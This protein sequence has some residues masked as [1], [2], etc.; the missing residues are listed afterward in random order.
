MEIL[1]LTI[2][3]YHRAL[4]RGELTTRQLVRAYLDRIEAYDQ[5]G[6]RI[7]A[8]ISTN[9]QAME[10]AEELDRRFA[11]SGLT[12]PLHGV[13]VLLKDN[14]HTA[15]M[16]TTAGSESLRGFMAGSDAPLVGR[17]K[18]AGAI[19]LAKT[20]LHEFAIWGE[21]ISSIA[22]QTLNPYDLTRTPGGS[23]G[24]T[25][26]AVAANLGLVGIGTDTINSIRSPSSANA[27]VGIRPTLGRVSREGIVPYSYT[28]DTAGPMTRCVADAAR[29]L[30]VIQGF[31][32]ADEATASCQDRDLHLTDI[33]EEEDGLR[34]ARIGVLE[35]FFGHGPH[36]GAVNAAVRGALAAMERMGAVLVPIRTPLDA[37]ELTKNVSVHLYDLKDH[38]NLYLSKLPEN[39]PVHSMEEVLASGKF[40]PG[41]RE[42]LEQ[43]A[44][45]STGTEE[46]ARRLARG[47]ETRELI[48]QWMDKNNLDALA[49]PHQQQLVCKVG[50]AQQER[51]GVLASVTGFP[52]ICVPAGYSEA[53][54]TAPL[55]V[56]IGM[57]LLG[58]PFSERCLIGLAH[59]YEQGTSVRRMPEGFR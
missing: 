21:T 24:G 39:A 58:R 33:L 47:E 10:E 56:P 9:E 55:G 50:G 11:A 5:K 28:Q 13:P 19:I 42:N 14:I 34:G 1:E 23:S 44:Q 6:L 3:G 32:P 2:S 43:A 49:Y 57:E 48:L 18:D 51:N 7:N 41:I 37:V 35:S 26:A 17:L 40:H 46:Y 15:D 8:I 4:A 20:N 12:G 22:G 30:E 59:A 53:S 27:L 25:G 16:P 45:L 31:D 29:V 38:L 36:H 54:E 52:S